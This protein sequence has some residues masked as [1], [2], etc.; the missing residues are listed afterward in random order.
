MNFLYAS[1]FMIVFRYT[2]IQSPIPISF[3]FIECSTK[4]SSVLSNEALEGVLGIWVYCPQILKGIG[5]TCV[6]IQS[7]FR[8]PSQVG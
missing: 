4:S 8:E 2:D 1:T 5:D 3:N 7:T 6:K